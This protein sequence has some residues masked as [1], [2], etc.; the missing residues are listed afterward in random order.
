MGTGSA[1]AAAGGGGFKMA[2]SSADAM[3]VNHLRQSSAFGF[4]CLCFASNA[5]TAP[6]LVMQL[7]KNSGAFWP[8]KVSACWPL[9]GGS[10]PRPAKADG[11]G[12][13]GGEGGG[14]S[15]PGSSG[16]PPSAGAEAP[17]VAG[18]ARD[19]ERPGEAKRERRAGD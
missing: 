16:S 6:P 5:G 13:G 3:A 18:V 11:G 19:G 15:A 17:G 8:V 1:A 12:G 14:S 4:C 9:A 7:W 10:P 2:L